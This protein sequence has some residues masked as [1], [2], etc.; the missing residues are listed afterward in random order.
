M[1]RRLGLLLLLPL[2]LTGGWFLGASGANA[3]DELE[4]SVPASGAKL[5][6]APQQVVLTFSDTV[7]N[8]GSKVVVKDSSGKQVQDGA[9]KVSGDTVTQALSGADAD[10]SYAVTWRAVSA[11]GHPVSGNFSFSVS[12]SSASGSS[13]STSGASS[14]SASSAAGSSPSTSVSGSGWVSGL[15]RSSGSASAQPTTQTPTDST[16]NAPWLIA[17][18]VVV[19]LLVI[20]G[21]AAAIRSRARDDDADL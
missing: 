9:A 18:A 6:S 17:G 19:G 10:G 21:V 13:S 12:G 16:N 5:N 8:V 4:K 20:G 1:R 15:S 2:L 14:S 11:D 7:Q 3:H